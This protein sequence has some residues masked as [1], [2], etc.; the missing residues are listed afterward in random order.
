MGN[1]LIAH[2]GASPEGYDVTSSGTKIA[3]QQKLRKYLAVT[4][5]SDAPVYLALANSVDGVTSPAEV[6][7]GIYLAPEGGSY[8]LNNVNMYFDEIWAIH[9]QAGQMKRLCVQAGR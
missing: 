9:D 6:G 1:T 8:E 5:T 2:G 7:K 3:G 4:N